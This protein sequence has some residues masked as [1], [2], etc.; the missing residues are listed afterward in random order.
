MA[1]VESCEYHLHGDGAPGLIRCLHR[2]LDCLACHVLGIGVATRS[3]DCLSQNINASLIIEP[4]LHVYLVVYCIMMGVTLLLCMALRFKQ[5]TASINPK[6]C[7]LP[8]RLTEID[9]NIF[10]QEETACAT[11]SPRRS[12]LEPN[13]KRSAAPTLSGN[14][15]RRSCQN[16]TTS[17]YRRRISAGNWAPTRTHGPR[18][19]AGAPQPTAAAAQRLQRVAD[20]ALP[21]C[22]K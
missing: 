22:S 21:C 4:V 7:M 20:D 18:C 11:Y 9:R 8:R 13:A 2:E 3:S 19:D 12:R 1:S 10:L 17:H 14:S 6:Q 15:H 16:T 5:C